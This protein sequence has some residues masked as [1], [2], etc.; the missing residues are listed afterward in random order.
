[1]FIVCAATL[2]FCYLRSKVT[3]VLVFCLV[4]LDLMVVLP[5]ML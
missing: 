3:N 2:N 5:V 1:M 4:I